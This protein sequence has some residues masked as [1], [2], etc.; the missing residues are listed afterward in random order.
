[1]RRRMVFVLVMAGLALGALEG[2]A[3]ALC[4]SAEA[5]EFIFKV[6]GK[7]LAAG[8][9]EELLKAADSV[10]YKF[11]KPGAPLVSY[12][13]KGME[14]A[15]KTSIVGGKPG[16]VSLK[17]KWTTCTG[18]VAGKTCTGITIE[19]PVRLKGEIVEEI[20]VPKEGFPAVRLTPETGK[21]VVKFSATCGGLPDV[22]VAEGSIV[23]EPQSECSSVKEVDFL[24]PG[25]ISEVKNTGGK[26]KT[27]TT[28]E[29]E[30]FTIE[31]ATFFFLFNSPKWGIC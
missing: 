27:P 6:G 28:M 14:L 22:R 7:E 19:T 17:L 24:F 9:T 30:S 4:S 18:S 8:K 5:G 20:F 16:T 31:G 29:G 15:E 26:V 10:S 21:E 12:E 23:F 11:K 3:L 2:G 25:F 13:C 1:M